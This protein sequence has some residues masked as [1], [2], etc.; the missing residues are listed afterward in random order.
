M[1]E[2]EFNPTQNI[3]SEMGLTFYWNTTLT[4]GELDD[5]TGMVVNAVPQ[6]NG[7]FVIDQSEI[8]D[9]P[10]WNKNSSIRICVQYYPIKSNGAGDT[11]SYRSR[12]RFFNKKM[13]KFTFYP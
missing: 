1:E 6:L 3:T 12:F 9:A 11:K 7:Y 2:E 8:E 4:G 5:E 10:E 13:S